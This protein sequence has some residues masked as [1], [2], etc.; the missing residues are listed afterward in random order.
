MRKRAAV[1]VSGNQVVITVEGTEPLSLSFP[2]EALARKFVSE[3][4]Q[5]MDMD[6]GTSPNSE[7]TYAKWKEIKDKALFPVTKAPAQRPSPRDVAELARSQRDPLDYEP[8]LVEEGR[9][10]GGTRAFSYR[11]RSFVPVEDK[12]GE[13]TTIPMS[14]SGLVV[15]FR[16]GDF[17]RYSYSSRSGEFTLQDDTTP[18]EM[19]THTKSM[20][21]DDMVKLLQDQ[22]HGLSAI[23]AERVVRS[24]S[25]KRTKV[26][27]EPGSVPGVPGLPPSLKAR[28][29]AGTLDEAGAWAKAAEMFYDAGNTRAY[30]YALRKVQEL[31]EKEP[32]LASWVRKNCKF[33][34]R[35]RP[36]GWHPRKPPL[37]WHPLDEKAEV[38]HVWP[39]EGLGF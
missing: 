26:E 37:G 31:R 1:Q 16:T 23:E 10:A 4:G 32:A 21:A 27:S 5:E 14:H 17:Q 15:V 28:M 12:E 19:G 30:E 24:I 20:S 13:K 35:E 7:E 39:D 36:L 2:S 29:E 38:E 6:F 8:S 9:G 25:I 3:H 33:A 22:A 34:A 11:K 18:G